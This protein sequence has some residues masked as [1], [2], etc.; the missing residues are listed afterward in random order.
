MPPTTEIMNHT[1]HSFTTQNTGYNINENIISS[2]HTD[3]NTSN[4]GR[5]LYNEVSQLPNK[6]ANI[7]IVSQNQ[8]NTNSSITTNSTPP[9]S[10]MTQQSLYTAGNFASTSGKHSRGSIA[11]FNQCDSTKLQ[12]G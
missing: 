5:I 7:K 2:S 4:T 9:Y 8:S 1:M 3:I 11:D 6:F 12:K 10:N